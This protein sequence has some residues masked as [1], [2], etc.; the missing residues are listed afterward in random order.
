MA[1][2]KK[3]LK[4]VSVTLPVQYFASFMVNRFAIE[5]DDGFTIVH[6]GLISKSGTLL[7]RY[8]AVFQESML[9]GQKE[10]LVQYSDKLGAVKTTIPEW[11]P[12][13]KELDA[14]AFG[15]Q[16]V[17][18]IHL[19]SWDDKDAEICFMNYSRAKMS[20]LQALQGESLAAWG[21]ALIR[22]RIDLQRD[23]LRKLYE[24]D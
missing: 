2:A 19:T 11:T 16:V 10:N 13:R 22:C 14:S 3:K 15:P 18:Y 7:D 23:F 24:F 4:P 20:D 6:F 1:P 5:R 8:S 12:P 17:D 21:V 9:E